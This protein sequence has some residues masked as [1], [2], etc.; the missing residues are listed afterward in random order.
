MSFYKLLPVLCIVYF[1]VVYSEKMAIKVENFCD[2]VFSIKA[3]N[4]AKL[5]EEFESLAVIDTPFTEHA[6][7]LFCNKTKNRYKNITPCELFHLYHFY[8]GRNASFR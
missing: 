1:L 6:A 5:I 8:V 4:C 7:K 2:H 3:Q